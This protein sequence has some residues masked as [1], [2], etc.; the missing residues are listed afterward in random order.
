MRHAKSDPGRPG[1]DFERPLNAQGRK[2]LK[3]MGQW[4]RL[5]H[6]MPDKLCSSPA[7]RAAETAA[8][9]CPYLGYADTAIHWE[10]RLYLAS[11]ETLLSFLKEWFGAYSTVMIVGHNPGMEALLRHMVPAEA[12]EGYGALLPTAGVAHLEVDIAG[13]NAAGWIEHTRACAEL[14]LLRHPE[15]LKK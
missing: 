5:V 15:K 11:L 7:K 14:K 9:I 3:E 2:S 4:L 6:C 10:S 12:L 13:V 8:G 1:A